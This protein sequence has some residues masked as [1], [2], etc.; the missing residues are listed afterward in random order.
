MTGRRE[1]SIGPKIGLTDESNL[2]GRVAH[3]IVGAHAIAFC[4]IEWD[5]DAVYNPQFRVHS[6]QNSVLPRK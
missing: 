2:V 4:A 6:S 1:H 3:T 5:R